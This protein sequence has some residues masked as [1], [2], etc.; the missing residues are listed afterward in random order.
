MH[1]EPERNKLL[2]CFWFAQRVFVWFGFVLS[3]NFHLWI[4]NLAVIL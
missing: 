4:V 2:D 1:I 3:G